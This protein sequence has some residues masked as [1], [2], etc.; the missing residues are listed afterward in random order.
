MGK[1]YVNVVWTAVV[2]TSTQSIARS[3]RSYI[4]VR[5]NTI[6]NSLLCSHDCRRVK[7]QSQPRTQQANVL[8]S[9]YFWRARLYLCPPLWLELEM[10][11]GTWLWCHVHVCDT[12]TF[13][14]LFQV[15]VL[16]CH[17]YLHHWMF[18]LPLFANTCTV[19]IFYFHCSRKNSSILQDVGKRK[20]SRIHLG[21]PS[22]LDHWAVP[23]QEVGPL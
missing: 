16:I 21:A 9:I 1:T 7:V 4:P 3:H 19:K 6:W 10:T 15:I 22:S 14:L 17:F 13:H 11:Q 2:F 12:T 18:W 23:A 8:Q 5:N 20:F